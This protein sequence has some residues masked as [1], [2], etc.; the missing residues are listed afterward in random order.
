MLA[1]GVTIA[2]KLITGIHCDDVG[3]LIVV[4][5]LLSL[6]NAVLKP[7]LVLFTLPFILL[8]LGL[9]M[10]VINA[11]L[12]MLVGRMVKGFHVAGFWPALGG[13]LIVSIT[14]MIVSRLIG[15]KPPRPPGGRS[16]SPA[17]RDDVIDI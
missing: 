5:L 10:L 17:K 16:A 2:T 8:S 15:T 13:A 4:V 6:F 7:I 14:N 3:T 1:L 9:G 12:F 11:F